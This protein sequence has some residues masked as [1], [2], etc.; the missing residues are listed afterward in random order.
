MQLCW[1]SSR[2]RFSSSKTASA[3]SVQRSLVSLQPASLHRLAMELQK[4]RTSSAL[5]NALL[6]RTRRQSSLANTQVLTYL[7]SSS[8]CCRISLRVSSNY[9]SPLPL[10][11]SCFFLLRCSVWLFVIS[12]FS[13]NL[14][15]L[16]VSITSYSYNKTSSH[17]WSV[18]NHHMLSL[19]T[20]RTE[21]LLWSKGRRASSSDQGRHSLYKIWCHSPHICK[22]C[23]LLPRIPHKRTLNYHHSSR[24]SYLSSYL[25]A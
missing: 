21:Y 16:L 25:G 13:C 1:Q 11:F 22:P 10:L 9:S 2:W 23:R 14:F 15:T 12:A 3:A 24:S 4:R 19:C 5:R 18:T 7:N 17:V 20:T 8:V 6:E